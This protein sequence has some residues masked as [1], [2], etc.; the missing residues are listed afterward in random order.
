MALFDLFSGSQ[1]NIAD[2]D[3]FN[4]TIV[5]NCKEAIRKRPRA[6]NESRVQKRMAGQVYGVGLSGSQLSKSG[7]FPKAMS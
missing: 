7:G 3:H 2:S 1:R 4:T 5:L 6:I